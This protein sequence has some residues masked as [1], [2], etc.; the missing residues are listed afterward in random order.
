ML[1]DEAV[2]WKE[3]GNEKFKNGSFDLAID[4]YTLSIHYTPV[5]DVCLLGVLYSNRA[6]AYFKKKQFNKAKGDAERCLQY[7]PDWSKV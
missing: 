7:R 3:R 6:H 5:N 4:C 1:Q 2:S